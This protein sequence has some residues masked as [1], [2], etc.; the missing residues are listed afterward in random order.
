MPATV[1]PICRVFYKPM[2]YWVIMD[3]GD[4]SSKIGVRIYKFSMKTGNKESAFSIEHFVVGLW[5][6]VEKIGELSAQKKVCFFLGIISFKDIC[7]FQLLLSSK[8]YHQVEVIGHKTIGEC[9]PN[10]VNVFYVFLEKIAVVFFRS[11]KVL[12]SACMC[13]DVIHPF[14]FQWYPWIGHFSLLI[15]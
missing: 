15:S 13:P 5:V 3:I 12:V 4:K 6:P 10:R 1:W 2:V 7:F 8:P 9:L 11:E 14:R